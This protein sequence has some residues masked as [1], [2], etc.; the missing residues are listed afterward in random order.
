MAFGAGASAKHVVIIGQHAP[1]PSRE[2]LKREGTVEHFHRL[3]KQFGAY[4][5][6]LI[7]EDKL[8]NSSRL[9][10]FGV[11]HMPSGQSTWS[12]GRVCLLGD[13]VHATTPFMGQGANQAMQ[14]AYCLARLLQEH[15]VA[16]YSDVFRKYHAI[17]EPPT[18]NIIDMSGQVGNF[19]IP[20]A[21]EG[22]LMGIRRSCMYALFHYLPSRF[23]DMLVKQF[24]VIA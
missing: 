24:T 18:S 2:D 8:R 5:A 10:H 17:R 14:S 23:G 16:D 19:R 13:A 22:C 20:T 15:D 6:G 1:E 21:D 3:F 7:S 11:Y 12:K 4:D 9:L